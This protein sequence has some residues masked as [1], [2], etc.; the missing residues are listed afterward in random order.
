[1]KFQTRAIHAGQSADP[2]T[3]ATVI[4]INMTTTFT[5]EG[6]G[7]HEGYEY[8]RTGNPTREALE[9][10][11]ASLEEGRHGL[12][13]ASG[14]AATAA[15]LSTMRPGDHVVAAEDMYGGTR[16]YFDLASRKSGIE[17]TFV[18]GRDTGSFSRAL[19]PQTKMVWVETPSNPLLHLTDIAGMADSLR[20]R[21]ALLVVDNTFATPW[22]QQPLKLG[23]D[24][25]VHS[26]TKYINGHSDAV[27]GAVIT[28]SQEFFESVRFYQNAGGAV[29]GPFE[30]WLTLRGVR[31]LALRM[32][33]HCRNAMHIADYLNH[34]HLLERLIY[35]GLASHPQHSLAKRQMSGFGGMVTLELKGGLEAADRFVRALEIFSYAESLGGVESLACHPGTMTHGAIPESERRRRGITGGLVRLSIGIEAAED[36]TADIEQALRRANE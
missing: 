13:F 15:V 22:L 18:D 11:L 17:F 31:T 5:Q 19:R 29:P 28:S 32:E 23:A 6:I 33:R 36:L 30:S 14:S 2:T 35:P 7:V 21:R 3:G 10:C 16:R 27:G 26:T 20:G 34:H 12:A 24:V 1:M 25:V 9:V 4:P 8:S